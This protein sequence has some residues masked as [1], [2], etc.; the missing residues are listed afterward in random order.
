MLNLMPTPH[1][2]HMKETISMSRRTN[3]CGRHMFTG[4]P[5]V[6]NSHACDSNISHG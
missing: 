6:H 3:H 1:G 5:D 4:G 2:L